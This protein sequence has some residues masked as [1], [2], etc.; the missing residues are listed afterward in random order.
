MD[1]MIDPPAGAGAA[2]PTAMVL[3]I[4]VVAAGLFIIDGPHAG[5]AIDAVQMLWWPAVGFWLLAAVAAWRGRQR[6]WV[7][8]S[9]PLV[10]FPVAF[11]GLLVIYCWDSCEL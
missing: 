1:R 10:I 7:V 11:Y 8:T 2:G 9:A 3:A 4:C 5:F 6:L